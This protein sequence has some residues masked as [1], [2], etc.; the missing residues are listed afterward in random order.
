V[1][2]RVFVADDPA[3]LLLWLAGRKV[4]GIYDGAG[5]ERVGRQE[6][7]RAI[8]EYFRLDTGLMDFVTTAELKQPAARP[9]ASGLICERLWRDQA[10]QGAPHM[11]GITEGLREIDWQVVSAG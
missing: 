11:H 3:N 5:P 7:A 6:W 4:T 10:T 9:R 8:A 1:N 2:V